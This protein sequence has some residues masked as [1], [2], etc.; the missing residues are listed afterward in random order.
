[1]DEGS[2][3][4][5]AKDFSLLYEHKGQLRGHLFIGTGFGTNYHLHLRT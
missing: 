5:R 3:P 2:I 4:D 1:M